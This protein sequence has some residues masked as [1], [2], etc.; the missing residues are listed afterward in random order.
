[1]VRHHFRNH[2]GKAEIQMAIVPKKIPERIQFYQQRVTQW[3][4]NATAIGLTAGEMTTMSARVTAAANALA[5]Q[6]T[7]QQAAKDATI[8]LHNAVLLLGDYGA[9]LIK[10]IKAKAGQA[11]PG[12]YAL[13]SIPAP[14]IPSPVAPPGTPY[15]F[16]V[17]LQQDGSMQLKW[18][19]DNPKGSSGTVYQVWRRIEPSSDYA[20]LGGVGEKQFT[21]ATLPKG[22]SMITYQIQAVRSTAVGQWGEFNVNFGVTSGGTMTASVTETPAIAA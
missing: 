15:K 6:L 1:M 16:E 18:K 17:V 12:V 8:V 11:G 13:A 10:Q 3:T 14:A 2:A 4:D 20:Y 7:A 22:A 9:T 21:N 19:C 5:A